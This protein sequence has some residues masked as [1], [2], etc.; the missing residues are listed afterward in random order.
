MKYLKGGCPC[1]ACKRATGREWR[2]LAVE[3]F[4]T[5]MVIAFAVMVAVLVLR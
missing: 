4:E 2:R 3:V 5:L 1:R